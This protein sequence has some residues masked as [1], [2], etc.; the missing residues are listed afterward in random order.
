M[1]PVQNTN[2]DNTR[3]ARG[4]L[5]QEFLPPGPSLSAFTSG[6]GFSFLRDPT[7]FHK[8]KSCHRIRYTNLLARGVFLRLRLAVVT[9]SSTPVSA[10]RDAV[11]A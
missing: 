10:P 5:T 2:Y 9:P 3:S 6:E 1:E 11:R 4:T 8:A 7:R